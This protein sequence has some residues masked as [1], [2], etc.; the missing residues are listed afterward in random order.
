MEAGGFLASIG[1]VAADHSGGDAILSVSKYEVLNCMSD[2]KSSCYRRARTTKRLTTPMTMTTM[3]A[4]ITI[5]Q[6]ASPKDF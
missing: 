1:T 4:L 6:N 2:M 5:L 3:P